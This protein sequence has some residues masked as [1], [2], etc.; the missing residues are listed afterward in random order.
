MPTFKCSAILFDLDGVL[1]DSTPSVTRQWSLWAKENHIDPKKAVEIA[2]GRRTIESV[3][4]LAPHVDAEAET[5]KIEQREVDDNEG[6]VVMRGADKLLESLPA[7]RWCVVTSGTRRLAASRLKVG[8]LPVP[9]VL[10][11]ADDVVNG[12][13]HPEPYLKGAERLKMNPTECLVIEDAPAG[14]AAA[15]AA[16]MKVIA[17]TTTYPASALQ[18]ADA[19]VPAL[20]DVTVSVSD[21]GLTVELNESD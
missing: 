8:D 12:K 18:E 17:L 21:G 2:H 15:H 16:G 13:P 20:K 11:S 1:V 9:K 14:I 7:A 5:K 19:I 6:V 10:I 3:R 4:M